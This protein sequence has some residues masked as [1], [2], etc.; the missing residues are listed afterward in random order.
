MSSRAPLR[1]HVAGVGAGGQGQDRKTTANV[2]TRAP[3]SARQRPPIQFSSDKRRNPEEILIYTMRSC[4]FTMLLL[5][6]RYQLLGSV[7]RGLQIKVHLQCWHVLV[8]AGKY[9]TLLTPS[10]THTQR[11][12]IDTHALITCT[13]QTHTKVAHTPCLLARNHERNQRPKLQLTGDAHD[14]CNLTLQLEI[15]Y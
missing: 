12:Q 8:L 13:H 5:S 2:Q 10:H 15:V 1:V 11:T 7:V 3:G 14:M 9:D 4:S 6:M